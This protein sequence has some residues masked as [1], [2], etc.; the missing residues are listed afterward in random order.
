MEILI[1]G[2]SSVLKWS[3][4]SVY[5]P[6]TWFGCAWHVGSVSWTRKSRGIVVHILHE[7]GQIDGGGLRFRRTRI[8]SDQS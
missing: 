7:D 4:L 3:T 1:V 2:S 8:L 6:F 5:K